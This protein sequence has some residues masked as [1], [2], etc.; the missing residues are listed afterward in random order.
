V[1][2]RY[3]SVR[4]ILTGLQAGFISNKQRGTARGTVAR[5]ALCIGAVAALLAGCSGAQLPIG[6]PDAV[7]QTRAIATHA[8]RG[9]SW[10][11]PE[12]KMQDL[13]YVSSSTA[14]GGYQVTV[15][16]YPGGRQVGML[17]VSGANGLCSDKAGNVYI[18]EDPDV[19][20]YAHGGTYPIATFDDLLFPTNGCA[21]DPTTGDLAVA[22]G[23]YPENA[24]VAIFTRPKSPPAVYSWGPDI[25]FA[26]CSYD[27]QGNLFTNGR[28]F[29]QGESGL[30]ELSKGSSRLQT[31]NVQNG[32]IHGGGAIQWDGT[33]LALVKVHGGLKKSRPATIYQLQ[34]S[35]QSGTIVNA[36]QL[37]GSLGS[38]VGFE[39][40]VQVWIEK[41]TI[42]SPRTTGGN[43]A[44]LWQY[45]A[46]GNPFRG[47]A[48]V[49]YP[50]Y[51]L[52]VSD[53]VARHSRAQRR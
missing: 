32:S 35:G 43:R 46:G 28:N 53:Y 25:T 12:A 17:S 51:G 10:M 52:T 47:N 4:Q 33:Y 23:N 3:C 15:F 16:S 31:I 39:N 13:L 40:S 27:A 26:W 48:R 6:T 19:V 29:R 5:Y 45:P 50:I 8:N 2:P 41:N 14:T 21:V 44:G 9:A 34:I 7:S 36:V 22:G 24:K 11:L 38:E 42:V 20:E 30:V 1:F 37:N 49:N 18:V